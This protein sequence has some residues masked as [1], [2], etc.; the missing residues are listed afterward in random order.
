M[1]GGDKL[2]K[3]IKAFSLILSF[4]VSIIFSLIIYGCEVLPDSIKLDEYNAVFSGIY[5]ADGIASVTPVSVNNKS[6]TET[7]GSSIK[8][9]GS[10]PVKS[11]NIEKAD[12]KYV[13]PGGELIG[14]KLKTDGVLIVGTESFETSNGE[15]CPAEKAGLQVGDTLISIDG[16]RITLNSQLSEIFANSEGKTLKMKIIRD[17]K[18]TEIRITPEKDSMTGVFKGGLWIRD[19]TG[20]IGTLTYTDISTG[21]LAALGHGIYDVDT[22]KL[23]PTLNGIFVSAS[24]SGITKGTNGSAGELRGSLGSEYLGEIYTNCENGIYG[25]AALI[26]NLENVIPV[27]FPYE[28][29]TGPAQI[30]STVHGNEKCYYDIEIDKINSSNENKN[31]IIRVT[32]KNLLELTGG[33]VQGMSGSPIIQNGQIVGAVT[34]VFLNDPTRGYGIFIDNMMDAANSAA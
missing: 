3:I 14:I 25:N 8:L 30:I 15:V 20:G 5:K 22:G 29:K 28:V 23:L 13:T 26:K 9:F 4:F 21:E 31:M 32:D 27:A 10:F 17:G 24:L 33:I 16:K 12:R 1:H 2:K 7:K 11:V 18:E 34:H 6:S 19:S